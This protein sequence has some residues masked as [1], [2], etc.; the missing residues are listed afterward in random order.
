MAGWTRDS[1]SG[2]LRTSGFLLTPAPVRDRLG[3]CGVVSHGVVAAESAATRESFGVCFG[4]HEEEL[5][6]EIL[7]LR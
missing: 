7:E 2:R 5:E 6:S 3:A 4:R 1:W